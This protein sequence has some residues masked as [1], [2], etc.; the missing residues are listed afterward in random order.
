MKCE[1]CASDIPA[2]EVR[3]HSGRTLCE[4]CYLEIMVTPKTCDPWAVYSA[5]NTVSQ[6]PV[7]T[8]EQQKIYDLIKAEGPLSLE[9]ICGDLGLSEEEFRR[10]FATLRH[11]ELAKASKREGE[12]CFMLFEDP[13]D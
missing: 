2:D 11:M 1:K 7:L 13:S 5:K 6:E 8:E 10:S 3:E 9:R 4:D 12:V